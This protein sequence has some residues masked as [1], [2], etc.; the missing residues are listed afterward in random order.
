MNKNDL[1]TKPHYPIL[2]GLR[3]V[4]AIIVVTFHLGEPLSTSNL[5]KLVNHGYLAVDFF[6][7]LS[8]FV[9]GYAYDDRWP[10][11]T[12]G[13]FFKRRIERLQPMV[14]LG[15][16]LGAVGFYFTDST[17]WPLIHTIP[18]WKMLLVMLV[19]YTILPVPLSLDIRG[20]EE[21]HPLNSVG[22]SLFFEYIANILY[23]VW[24]RKFS[25]TALSVFVVIAAIALAQMAITNGD[26]SGGWTL[27]IPQVRIGLTR[28]IFP[29]F[30]GLLL[31][32]LAKPTRIKNAF[33][34]C[35]LLVAIVLYMPRIG[36]AEYLWMNG[37]YE[38]VC[39]IIVFPLIVYIGASGVIKSQTESKV[40]KFL[41][42]ISYPLYMVHYPL[43]YFYVAWISNHKG[44]TIAQVWPYA[45][46][47]LI[48][49]IAL[50][51]AALKWYDEPVRRWLRKKLG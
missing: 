38:S 20:W 40:C 13:T 23:A 41:G 22:W 47:I 10:K 36:G 1:A 21:M 45:L 2:D 42:D 12:V 28:T 46:L 30:A 9:I 50:A 31:S 39:I 51:Y 33:L 19:G 32:R 25:K 18:V 5:D 11:M 8:G 15:M 44:I 34:W 7:L 48:T 24:I 43:V 49:A 17:L 4:A 14:V 3:G 37:L 6:F 35:S 29:F 16:T 26:V 27:N